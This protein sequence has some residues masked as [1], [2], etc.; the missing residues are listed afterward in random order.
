MTFPAPSK[1]LPVS[2]SS[3]AVKELRANRQR[4]HRKA[5]ADGAPV[6]PHGYF[7]SMLSE[8]GFSLS[9]EVKSENPDVLKLSYVGELDKSGN[10]T[11]I[12]GEQFNPL[13][14][15]PTRKS[16]RI[17][18]ERPAPHLK[19]QLSDAIENVPSGSGPKNRPP[20]A[21]GLPIITR[22]Q[23]EPKSDGSI[24]AWHAPEGSR[25]RAEK[26]YLG[27]VGKRLL[28]QWKTEPSDNIPAIVAEWISE[29]RSRKGLI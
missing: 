5:L 7:W 1:P 16:A 2:S 27:R 11:P 13:N 23:W 9:R 3:P 24:E 25:K 8:G 17:V 4:D 20:V 6:V 12:H 10:W 22:V 21:E 18:T 26:T 28:A 29:K 19:V 14:P 15:P